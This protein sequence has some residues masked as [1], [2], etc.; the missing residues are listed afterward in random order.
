MHYS[1]VGYNAYPIAISQNTIHYPNPYPTYS[2]PAKTTTTEE[3]MVPGEESVFRSKLMKLAASYLQENN[4]AE[5][6][7]KNLP[8][9]LRW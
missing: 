6:F 5:D 4:L 9:S 7:D 2:V 8:R 3:K 1:I